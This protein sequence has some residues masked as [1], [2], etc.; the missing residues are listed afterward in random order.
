MVVVFECDKA[1]RLQD[2]VLQAP[3][4]AEDFGHSVYRARLRLKGNFNE[5]SLRQRL[6]Q[7]EQATGYGNGLQFCFGAAAIFEANRSQDGISSWTRA[8]RR[9]GCGWGKWVISDCTIA[10][11]P[12]A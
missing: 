5:V 12:I 4:G 8:A 10:P 11:C 3:H 9:E 6:R 2:A 1:E 7:P